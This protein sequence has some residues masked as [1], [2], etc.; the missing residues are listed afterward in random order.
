MIKLYLYEKCSTCRKA[1]KH[2]DSK[3]KEYKKIPIID[4]PPSLAELKKASQAYGIKKLFNTSGEV[5]RKM[6]LK[7]KLPELSEKQALELLHKNGKLIKRPFAV[8]KDEIRV[9]F[10]EE[11]WKSFR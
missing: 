5:Y 11:E 8:H 7:E 9:G 3:K 1:V 10:K 2:L 4:Q 6:N